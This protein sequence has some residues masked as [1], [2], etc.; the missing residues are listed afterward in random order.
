MFRIFVSIDCVKLNKSLNFLSIYLSIYN[1]IV[2][3]VAL[4]SRNK[5]LVSLYNLNLIIIIEICLIITYWTLFPKKKTLDFINFFG[6]HCTLDF[7]FYS[8]KNI[9]LYILL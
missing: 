6:T 7:I 4:S 1:A 3:T 9:G 2:L 5:R 8:K